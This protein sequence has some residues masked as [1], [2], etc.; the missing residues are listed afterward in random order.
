[1]NA[2]IYYKGTD[3]IAHMVKNCIRRGKNF[4]G[5][6]M[7]VGINLKHFD[8]IWT[9]DD[10]NPIIDQGDI[11]GWDKNVSDLTPSTESVEIKP[12][13]RQDF[14]AAHKIRKAI[15]NMSYQELDSYIETNVTDLASAKVFLKTLAK[16]TLALCKMVDNK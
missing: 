10:A 7:K 2:V 4:V 11:I 8:V 3:K 13:T 12:P 5:D 14:I 1:M 15:D 9:E 16:V 6:N